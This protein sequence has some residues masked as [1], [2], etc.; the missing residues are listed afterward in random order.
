MLYFSKNL[1]RKTES[2]MKVHNINRL[3]KTGKSLYSFSWLITK[4]CKLDHKIHIL[5]LS[6]LEILDG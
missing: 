5:K 6:F 4:V 2:N 3:F 1:T